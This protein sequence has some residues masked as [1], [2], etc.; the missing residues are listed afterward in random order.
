MYSES[1][2][3][4]PFEFLPQGQD[5][6]DIPATG[7]KQALS[8]SQSIGDPHCRWQTY[9]TL[10]ALS[11]FAEWSEVYA[12]ATGIHMTYEDRQVRLIVP[13]QPGEPAAIASIQLNGNFRVCLVATTGTIDEIIE[14]PQAIV[15]QPRQLAHFYVNVMVNSEAQVAA[16]RGFLRYDQLQRYRQ[17]H[18]LIPVNGAYRIP[19]EQFESRIDRLWLLANSLNPQ[20]IPLAQNRLR[21]TFAPIKQLLIQPVINAG[22]WIQRQFDELELNGPQLSQQLDQ[23]SQALGN[24]LALPDDFNPALV[25]TFDN[26]RSSNAFRS[27]RAVALPSSEI[28]AFQAIQQQGYAIPVDVRVN[29]QDLCIDEQALRLTFVTWQLPPAETRS[30]EP[31]WS[32]LIIT[33]LLSAPSEPIQISIQQPTEILATAAIAATDSYTVLQVFGSLDEQFTVEIANTQTALVLPA[34][35]F[36]V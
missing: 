10:L 9:L 35:E 21:E 32:L 33:Q 17:Q 25:P 28:D 4:S 20:A 30:T 15:E 19:V 34:F 22:S 8:L 5:L 24:L 26:M 2:E 29:Y 31:E 16:V 3:L 12:A 1:V 14:L 11:G 13:S 27:D 6:V 36:A 18:D 23:A 7:L